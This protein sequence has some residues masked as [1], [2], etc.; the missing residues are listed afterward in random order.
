MVRRQPFLLSYTTD[1]STMRSAPSASWLIPLAKWMKRALCREVDPEL[2]FPTAEMNRT[3]DAKS[4]CQRCKVKNEC[5]SWAMDNTDS[6]G[7][8]GGTTEPERRRMRRYQREMA[9]G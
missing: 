3:K 8:L 4:V 1:P 5:L 9:T 2:F 7:V 6:G